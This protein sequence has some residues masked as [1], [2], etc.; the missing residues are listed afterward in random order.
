MP[1]VLKRDGIDARIVEESKDSIQRSLSHNTGQCIPLN[2]LVQNCV[3]YVKKY[4]LD[5]AKTVMWNI[6]S[7]LACNL[8]IFP[9]Y[10]KTLLESIGGGME[11]M[12]VYAGNITFIDV[13][14]STAL[15]MYQAYMLGG[16]LR[17]LGCK[18]RPYETEKGRT[19]EAI[20][21]SIGMLIKA[22]S[23]KLDLENTTDEITKLFEAI[24]VK[25]ETRPKV[26][27]FGDLYARDNDVLN[28][29][30]IK[31]IEENGGEVITTPY[32]E[33]MKI[34][35]EPYIQ[36]WFREGSYADAALTKVLQPAIGI[37]ER[38]YYKYFNRILNEPLPGSVKNIE[39]V[40]ERFNIKLENSGES[41]EN[42]LKIYS[43]MQVH[44]D[45]ALFVQTN[46]AFC[47]PS[48]VTQAMAQ[49]IEKNTGIPIVTIEYDGTGGFKN[50]DI[51]PYLKFPR[52]KQSGDII[53]VA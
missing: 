18:V 37:F 9:Y 40:L 50:S 21:K 8:G 5:P 17:R 3:D 2:I 26:A 22:F 4:G 53:C 31:V 27:I 11:K 48:L 1:A 12:D 20:E 30:I 15:N 49:H 28:Q 39:S 33:L 47:C 16:M 41:M 45:I 51:I 25:K 35:A 32:S 29:N 6:S 34:I 23:E 19:D 10:S 24:P 38:K 46:P 14:I 44:N 13:K 43:L 52:E 42:I 7:G 36:K